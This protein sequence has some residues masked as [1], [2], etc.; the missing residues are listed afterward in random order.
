MQKAD[1]S[2]N[3]F[4]DLLKSSKG[5][6]GIIIKIRDILVKRYSISYN[7]KLKDQEFEKS[8]IQKIF[9]LSN[10]KK[11]ENTKLNGHILQNILLILND[12]LI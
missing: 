7:F 8:F 12:N 5:E 10:P 1:V 2:K 4:E 3:E 6:L 11:I 9:E